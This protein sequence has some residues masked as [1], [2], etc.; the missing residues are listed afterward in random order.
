MYYQFKK[1]V[2]FFTQCYDRDYLY[3]LN[4]ERILNTTQLIKLPYNVIINLCDNYMTVKEHCEILRKKKL[5]NNYFCVNEYQYDIL[6]DFDLTEQQFTCNLNYKI[7]LNGM[8]ALFFCK[9]RYLFFLT[10]DSIPTY[11]INFIRDC[12]IH[13]KQTLELCTYTLNWADSLDHPRSQSHFYKEDE[14]FLY[15]KYFSDQNFLVNKN[16]L[17]IKKL[18][19][20]F[21]TTGYPNIDDFES[22]FSKYMSDNNISRAIY[23]AGNYK[24][25]NFF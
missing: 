19:Q 21:N 13:D 5:I 15:D 2:S 18:L 12:L 11:M 10:G 20:E 25:Q 14:K 9:T 3:V 24:H 8:A 6:K 1:E 7:C 16:H 23:K 22:R 4:E 17:I